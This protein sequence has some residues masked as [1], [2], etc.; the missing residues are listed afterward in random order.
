VVERS[1]SSVGEG[2][3]VVKYSTKVG[4]SGYAIYMSEWLSPCEMRAWRAYIIGSRRLYEA[5]DRDLAA[6]GLSMA[7]YEVIAYLSEAPERR[8][9][10]S[11][12]A[13][14]SLLSRSRLSHRMKV[15]EEAGIVRRENCPDDRRGAFAVL[16]EKG[17][18][19]IVAAAP[20]HVTSVRTRFIDLLAH[21][22]Q[23]AIALVFERVGDRLHE[24]ENV[25]S[26]AKEA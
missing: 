24:S 16:T 8:V 5:M 10:M 17:W 9:R 14:A 20:D 6:H 23:E 11:E 2:S 1:I 15:L 26:C 4:F 12:L 18:Q 7:D 25:D 13:Q 22:E 19:A 3:Q 21:N